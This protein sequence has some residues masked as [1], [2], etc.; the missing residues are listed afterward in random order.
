MEEDSYPVGRV[1]LTA[2]RYISPHQYETVL[3]VHCE[4]AELMVK[5]AIH[6]QILSDRW[7]GGY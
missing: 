5:V 3:R 2:R 6:S 1:S 7:M 4:E